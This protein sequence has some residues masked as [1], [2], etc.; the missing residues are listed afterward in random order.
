MFNALGGKDIT[1]AATYTRKHYEKYKATEL[2]I[3][4]IMHSSLCYR[5]LLAYEKE[6]YCGKWMK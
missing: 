6:V 2:L 4:V 1:A 5:Y 3:I